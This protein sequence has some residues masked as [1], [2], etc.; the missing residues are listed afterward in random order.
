MSQKLMLRGLRGQN[1][2]RIWK[3]NIPM[4]NKTNNEFNS[5]GSEKREINPMF[6][7]LLFIANKHIWL[8][9]VLIISKINWLFSVIPSEFTG[10]LSKKN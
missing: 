5:F 3:Q 9:Y 7:F 6:F 4:Q 1:R 10:E 2:L 8:G